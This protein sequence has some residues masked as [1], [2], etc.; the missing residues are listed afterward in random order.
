MRKFLGLFA[1][2]MMLGSALAACGGA[3]AAP[4]APAAATE[5]APAAAATPDKVTLQLKWVAQAQF[6]GY[7]AALEQGYYKDENLD[8][9]IQNGGPDIVPE[10]VVASGQAQFGIDWMAS[11][12]ATRETGAPLV[13]I[14]QV[15]TRAGMRA[16]SWKESNITSPADF[17]GK[18]VAVWFGGNEYNLLATL[19][20][21]SINKDSDLTLVQQPFDMNLL[22]NKEVDAAAAMTYNE[23]YQVLSAGHT[24]D[25]LNILDYN[26]EGTAM[27][28]DG[29]FVSADW[30][31]ADA[32]NKDIAA[33]FLRASFKGWAYCRDNVDACVDYV[34]KQ[35][36]GGVMTKE[37]QKWQMDEVNKLIWGDPID[38]N[39]KI[40][41]L[42]PELFT[43]AAD[44]A[45]SFGVIK[46]AAS[47]DAYTHEIWDM[48]TK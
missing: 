42:T 14:A 45:L 16:L 25:E 22:L 47:P 34:L 5:A 29:I 20:K 2:I 6:A 21:Y 41:Y 7:F 43:F 40:G 1:V 12:L 36:S 17:K 27:P 35:D 13:N 3:P 19:S 18:K 30:L 46:Q 4:A 8:V 39:T 24:I 26:A 9:T 11:L 15:Y 23:L 37:A 38:P 32:K 48:A 28:E 44:T 10:Q 33:R 31:N